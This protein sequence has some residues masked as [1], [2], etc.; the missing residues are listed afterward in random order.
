[1]ILPVA[2]VVTNKTICE[3]DLLKTSI[4]QYHRC[5]WAISCDDAAHEKYKN[6]QNI[7]CL[8]LIETDDCDHNVGSQLQKDNWMK[9][10]MTKF[11]VVERE[12]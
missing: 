10:M 8:K 3:F 9:V 7:K 6:I 11:D 12:G 4:E 2:S 1:M 5:E